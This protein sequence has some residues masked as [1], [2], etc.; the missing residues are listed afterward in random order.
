MPSCDSLQKPPFGM[1]FWLFT[2]IV[3]MLVFNL[4]R[5]LWIMLVSF[6]LVGFGWHNPGAVVGAVVYVLALVVA[7]GHTWMIVDY[8]PLLRRGWSEIIHSR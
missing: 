1:P 2:L 3:V 6:V 5:V 8:Y 4:V 7:I